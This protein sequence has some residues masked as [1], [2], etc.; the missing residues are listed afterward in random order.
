MAQYKVLSERF[1]KGK[2][3]EVV[4]SA[5][6]DECNI[7]SLVAGCHLAEVANK[8]TKPDNKTEEQ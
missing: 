3:G 4:D 5:D 2:V 8:Q 1:S 7:E 6:L